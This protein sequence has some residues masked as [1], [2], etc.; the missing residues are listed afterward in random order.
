M[1]VMDDIGSVVQSQH[2]I[3]GLNKTSDGKACHTQHPDAQWWPKAEL[4]MFVHWGISSVHGNIDLSWGMYKD[5]I[6]GPESITPEAYYALAKDFNPQKYDPKKWVKAAK[7]AGFNYMVLTT[8]HHDG[9]CLWPSDFG[10]LSTKN[11]MGGRDLVAEYVEACREYGMRIGLYYSPPDWSIDRPYMA[12]DGWQEA[13]P[14]PKFVEDYRRATVRGQIY[15]LLTRYGHIDIIWFDGPGLDYM[16]REEIY[17]YQPHIVIGRGNGYDFRSTE[18]ILAD[19]EK[20][21][22]DL[23]GYWYEHCDQWNCGGWGYTKDEKYKT[24]EKI[25]EMFLNTR[26]YDGNLLINIGPNKDGEF[27]DVVYERLAEFGEWMKEYRAR[28]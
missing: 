19:D 1:A 14:M 28:K 12:F 16:S 8:K 17:E 13:R 18:C 6:F 3:I 26:K 25:I 9:F 23:E 11:Y 20:Y 10:Y 24:T 27:P 21:H 7:D 4:G 5:W 15:E 22:K 2:D